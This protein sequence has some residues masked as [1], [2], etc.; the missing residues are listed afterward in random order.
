MDRATPVPDVD[1][2]R[3]RVARLR[4]QPVDEGTY[5]AQE[6]GDGSVRAALPSQFASRHRIEQS[7]DLRMFRYPDI[8][9]LLIFPQEVLDD[10]CRP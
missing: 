5:R 8:G 4:E 7:T 3:E 10:E 2:L 6:N 1:E 9:A